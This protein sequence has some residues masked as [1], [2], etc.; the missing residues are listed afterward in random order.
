MK[1][2]LLLLVFLA[3][4]HLLY[5]QMTV[6]EPKVIK[7][8][9]PVKKIILWDYVIIGANKGILEYIIENG[10]RKEFPQTVNYFV[11]P[12]L[13]HEPEPDKDLLA[14]KIL[15]YS[16]NNWNISLT[17]SDEKEIYIFSKEK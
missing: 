10:V 17:I 1:K 12:F 4:G 13:L 5:A 14:K 3:C 2:L 15:Y 8:V 9:A 16:E 11:S 6:P 7:Y